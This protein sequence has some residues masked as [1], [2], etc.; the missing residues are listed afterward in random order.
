MRQEWVGGEYPLRSRVRGDGI[1]DLQRE[2]W[3]RE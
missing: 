1:R 3:E 2:N